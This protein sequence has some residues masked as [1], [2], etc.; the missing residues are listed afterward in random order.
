MTRPKNKTPGWM[1][2]TLWGATL[3][4]ALLAILLP[5][6]SSSAASQQKSG[7]IFTLPFLLMCIAGGAGGALYHR[8]TDRE[9]PRGW[10]RPAGALV[11]LLLVATAFALSM[12]V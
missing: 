4:V 5:F 10:H 2:A 3:A 12:N 8:I 6:F 9:N 11:Y 1:T 7:D